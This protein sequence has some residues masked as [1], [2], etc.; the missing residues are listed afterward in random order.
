[1]D[2]TENIIKK[3]KAE[4]SAKRKATADR[5]A[6]K[7]LKALRKTYDTK[8]ARAPIRRLCKHAIKDIKTNKPVIFTDGF[9][10]A[11][12]A[13]TQRNLLHTL[14]E[15]RNHASYNNDSVLDSGLPKRVDIHNVVNVLSHKDKQWP[16]RIRRVS[17]PTVPKFRTMVLS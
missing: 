7:A 15:A 11:V 14:E 10:R 5:K 13:L 12:R 4:K 1:M 17:T 3:A 9:I 16:V 2:N 6:K 8:L